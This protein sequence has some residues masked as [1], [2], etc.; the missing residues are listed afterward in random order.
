MREREGVEK[1][2]RKYMDVC[3][4]VNVDLREGGCREFDGPYINQFHYHRNRGMSGF[5]LRATPRHSGRG[6]GVWIR[7]V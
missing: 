3:T 7:F 5:P 2:E 6:V 4:C 1:R